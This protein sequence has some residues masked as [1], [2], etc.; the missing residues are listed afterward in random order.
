MRDFLLSLRTQVFL[1]LLIIMLAA[2]VL[3]GTLMV[4]M[5]ERDILEEKVKAGREAVSFLV[6]M[7]GSRPDD[8]MPLL[9][10]LIDTYSLNGVTLL[11]ENRTV[12]FSHGALPGDVE[13]TFAG[14]RRAF[15]SGHTL[16]DIGKTLIVSSPILKDGRAV[17]SLSADFPLTDVRAR[18]GRSQKSALLYL[19]LVSPLLILLGAYLFFRSVTRPIGRLVEAT[20]MI[21]EGKFDYRVEVPGGGEL[22]HLARSFNVMVERLRDQVMALTR[23]HEK[24]NRA[25]EEIV[26]SEKLAS[27]GQMAAGIAHELGNPVSALTG[28]LDILLKGVRSKDKEKDILQGAMREAE[29]MDRIISGL[30]T[31]A[32]PQEA[33]IE[34]VDVNTVI[35]DT[36]TI[37][38]PQKILR[39]MD[40]KMA[41]Q[42]DLPPA[43]ADASLLTQVILNMIL[44]SK[45]AM[46]AGGALTLSTGMRDGGLEITV[47]DTGVGIRQ[48]DVQ[49]IFDPFFTTKE[50]G[51]GSGLGLSICQRIIDSFGGRILVE[52]ERGR[53]T[54]FTILLPLSG[55]AKAAKL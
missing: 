46:A 34:D 25:E 55:Q 50:P 16:V 9:Q 2:M 53:G 39:G 22:G 47:S 33:R 41:L 31:F 20:E 49:R 44:N 10:P 12:L 52:S 37:L 19:L 17:G 21:S 38:T 18:I 51:K 13:R 30:L 26:R 29:R 48:E 8:P 3:L 6:A 15:A 43:R 11:G 24:L 5:P 28:Y 1:I 23:A 40:V 54:T 27:L 42:D 14:A 7:A 45:D 36:L 35:R 32:R 4:K